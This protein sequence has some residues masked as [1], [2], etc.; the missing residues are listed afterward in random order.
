MPVSH[1]IVLVE[2]LVMLVL[3]QSDA[4]VVVLPHRCLLGQQVKT[5][6]EFSAS[7]RITKTTTELR[8]GGVSWQRQKRRRL[9]ISLPAVEADTRRIIYQPPN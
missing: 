9:S 1:T 7:L 2:E 3:Q 4:G 6:S 8:N 5:K